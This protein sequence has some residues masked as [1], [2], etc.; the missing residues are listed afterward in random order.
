MNLLEME[1]GPRVVN[2]YRSSLKYAKFRSDGTIVLDNTGLKVK[3][4]H[5]LSE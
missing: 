2:L 4:H 1:N 5:L 3:P